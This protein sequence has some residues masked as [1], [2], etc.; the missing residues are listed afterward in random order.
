MRYEMMFPNQ[1]REAIDRNSPVAL[2]V[3]VLEYHAEH[4]A[5]GT[6]GVVVAR[7]LEKT[8]RECPD[9]VLLPTFYYGAASYTVAPPER[10]GTI[11]VDAETVYQFARQLFKGLLRVGFRNIHA[12]VYH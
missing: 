8:E 4:C 2:A 7:M 1:V 5:L 9:L 6:D 3:G 11:H 12:F 10:N